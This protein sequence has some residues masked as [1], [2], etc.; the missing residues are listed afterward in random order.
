MLVDDACRNVRLL[1]SHSNF[2]RNRCIVWF[3]ACVVGTVKR[4]FIKCRCY[5]SVM[6][7]YVVINYVL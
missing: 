4:N 7:A 3:K 2:R 1:E 6:D 5:L